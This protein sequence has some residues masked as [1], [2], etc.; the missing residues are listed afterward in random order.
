VAGLG[1]EVEFRF[2]K[3]VWLLSQ[4]IAVYELCNLHCL[5]IISIIRQPGLCSQPA[6]A[7]ALTSYSVGLR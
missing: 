4:D 3:V 7:S 5:K 2:C 6:F 1:K